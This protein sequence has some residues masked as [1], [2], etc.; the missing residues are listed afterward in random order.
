MIGGVKASL[1]LIFFSYLYVRIIEVTGWLGDFL[2][3]K[4]GI[5]LK[6]VY[7]PET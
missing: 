6:K 2:I 3:F 4:S 7:F 5:A 1:F